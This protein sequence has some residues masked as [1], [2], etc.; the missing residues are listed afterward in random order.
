MQNTLIRLENV[1]RAYTMGQRKLFALREVSLGIGAGEFVAVVGPSGSGKSTLLNL[2]SG[3]DKPDTGRVWVDGLEVSA[4]SEN[5]LAKWRGEKIG[6]VFQFFQLLPTLTA[7]ENVMLPME[8]R[9]TFGDNRRAR[10]AEALARVGLADRAT[11]LPS[12]LSG[13]EQQRVAIARALANDPPILLADEPTGNLDTETGQRVVELLIELN[14]AGKTIVLVTHEE[15]LARAAARIVH[16]RDG[17]VV[18]SPPSPLQPSSIQGESDRGVVEN[19][20]PTAPPP[21]SPVQSEG[22]VA[23]SLQPT[24]PPQPS[25]SQGAGEMKESLLV[26]APPAAPPEP[27]FLQRENVGEVAES[28]QH[29]APPAT[30]PEPFFSRR[31][32][33]GGRRL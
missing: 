9:N 2:I 33:A 1:T 19:P 20:P 13:G 3:I 15:A 4:M 29:A 7:L 30:P 31:E 25:P 16:V 18:E 10:A 28:R 5:A 12:E 23:E 17:R 27:F 26:L 8:L 11:Q 14:H 21:P 22:G 6:V 32:D 24:I